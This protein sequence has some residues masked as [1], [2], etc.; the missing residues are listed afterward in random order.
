MTLLLPLV[1]TLTRSKSR[2]SF[3][4]KYH[5]MICLAYLAYR[6]KENTAEFS[7]LHG[8]AI[9]PHPW[10]LLYTTRP[11]S[12]RRHVYLAFSL[13]AATTFLIAELHSRPLRQNYKRE[14]TKY[15][16]FLR[17]GA[18][19]FGSA[20]GPSFLS[21]ECY[22]GVEMSLHHFSWSKTISQRFTLS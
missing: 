16:H 8:K 9:E 22:P 11:Q 20:H 2:S 21:L 5:A 14:P 19:M 12:S 7:L 1:K 17:I 6:V 15:T 18:F 3:R 13:H 4:I 10:R